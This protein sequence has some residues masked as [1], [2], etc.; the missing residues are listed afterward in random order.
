MAKKKNRRWGLC[1]LDWSRKDFLAPWKCYPHFLAAVFQ[2]HIRSQSK[3]PRFIEDESQRWDSCEM[4]AL[5]M[6]R[7]ACAGSRI[8]CLYTWS[9]HTKRRI[10]PW[11]QAAERSMHGAQGRHACV[12]A[13]LSCA[14]TR[15]FCL[16][17]ARPCQY[18]KLHID[19]WCRNLNKK[20]R[21]ENDL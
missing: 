17:L 20:F 2:I 21:M 14:L 11:G 19:M 12:C 5:W 10:D 15:T 8:R 4:C 16:P 18:V 9:Q 7:L 3:V 13:H 1:C 6:S